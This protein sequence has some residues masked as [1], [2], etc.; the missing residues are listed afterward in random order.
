[1]VTDQGIGIPKD[2]CQA[3]FDDFEQANDST[4]RN[5]GG[6]G[7][8]L[9]ITKKLTELLQFLIRALLE[10]FGLKALFAENGKQGVDKT[11]ELVAKGSPPDL[12]FM[13]IQMPVM[14]GVEATRQIRQNPDCQEIPIVG[15]SADAFIQQ[16]E[17]ALGTGMNKYLTKPVDP[18]KLRGV[19]DK[20]LKKMEENSRPP[21]SRPPK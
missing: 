6:T 7:L 8:G 4:S 16:Q 12:I 11:L 13:D 2:R 3:I 1:M 14:D 15:L 17:K 21:N 10:K 18:V 19:L 5:Y 20:Y 9:A